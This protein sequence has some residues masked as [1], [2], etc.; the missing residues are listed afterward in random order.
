MNDPKGKDEEERFWV[1]SMKIA[2]SFPSGKLNFFA[3]P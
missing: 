2:S 1:I 3:V